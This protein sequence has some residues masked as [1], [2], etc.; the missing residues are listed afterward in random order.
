[1]QASS[2]LYQTFNLF[3]RKK[4][5]EKYG[6][7]SLFNN[8]ELN[9]NNN[10]KNNN[11]YKINNNINV[12]NNDNN[13]NNNNINENINNKNN[14]KP[15]HI[16]I[17]VRKINKK[18]LNNHSSA[19]HIINLKNLIKTL[20]TIENVKVTAQD[21]AVLSFENQVKL[22]FNAQIF[23]S[24]HGAGTTHIFHMNIGF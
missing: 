24:M 12:N 11:N 22:S 10:N 1:M 7:D 19:R 5:L 23:L 4:W 9:N 13:N 18:K 20:K 16:V 17:E 2:P 15:I 6:Q 3:L 14:T 8:D 21:F